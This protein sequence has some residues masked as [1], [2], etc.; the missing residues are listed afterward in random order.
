MSNL[1]LL[2]FACVTVI[3]VSSSKLSFLKNIFKTNHITSKRKRIFKATACGDLLLK[4]DIKFSKNLWK[5]MCSSSVN[6]VECEI[7]IINDTNETITLCWVDSNGKL[8]H[9]YPLNDNSIEDGSVSNIHHETT[10]TNH[11]FLFMK[12]NVVS[13]PTHISNVDSEVC[14]Y[15]QAIYTYNYLLL[16]HTNLCLYR[17][18]YAPTDLC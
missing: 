5:Y 11:L 3:V 15:I 4:S 17:I 12:S 13:L 8:C 16:S 1:G 9:Y 6:N 14:I 7:D 18:L 10:L 2:M